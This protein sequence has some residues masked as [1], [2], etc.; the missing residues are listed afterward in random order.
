MSFSKPVFFAVVLLAVLAGFGVFVLVPLASS[1]IFFV[2]SIPVACLF[3]LIIVMRPKLALASLLFVRSLLDILLEHTKIE[4]GSSDTGIGGILNLLIMGLAILL[5]C[6][7]LAQ[8]PKIFSYIRCWIF[9]LLV[10]VISIAFSPDAI[11]A[12]KAL[13]QQ[14]GF[15]LIFLIPFFIVKD[16]QDKKFWL[17][18]LIFSSLL[19]VG[20]ADFAL[21]S[22]N[23]SLFLNTVDA[24]LRLQG[25]FTHP[26]IL[27]FYVVLV[28]VVAFFITKTKCFVLTSVQKNMIRLYML[29]LVVILIATK[30]R[31]ALLSCWLIF[32][33]YGLLKEKR[34][35]FMVLFLTSLLIL[36]PQVQERVRGLFS[37]TSS[38]AELRKNSFDWRMRL[39]S[40][41]MPLIRQKPIVGRGLG[42]FKI[43]SPTFFSVVGGGSLAHNVYVEL[44]FE[45]GILG[46][47]SYLGFFLL[48][49]KEFYLKIKDKTKNLSLESAVVF[50]FLIGHLVICLSDNM[51]DY[52]AFNWYFF[53]F[54]GLAA[55]SLYLTNTAGYKKP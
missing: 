29:N 8:R 27:A 1:N 3:F 55:R 13:L 45:T 42:S 20:L 52:V 41:S 10:C 51:L 50:S 39:W 14:A 22:R 37:K 31:S 33:M 6:Q 25:S 19:P 53:F 4:V 18:V 46:L 5:I 34:Y 2:F 16:E 7:N 43:L 49:M 44:L 47:M 17:K 48:L 54:L 11:K 9:F 21:V 32:A 35:F 26:N 15:M 36:T 28:L 12:F 38:R 30:T 40:S 24:G 23:R